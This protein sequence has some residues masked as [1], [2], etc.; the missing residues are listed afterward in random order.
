MFQK[1]KEL[2]LE[3][4]KLDDYIPKSEVNPSKVFIFRLIAVLLYI[5]YFSTYF[6][7]HHKGVM[8]ALLVLGSIKLFN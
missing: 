1:L 4:E 5:I 6:P 2:D 8:N 3:E 7:L